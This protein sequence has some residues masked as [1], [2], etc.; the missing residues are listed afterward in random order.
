MSLGLYGGTFDPIHLGHLVLAESL[1]EICGIERIAFVPAA[2]PPHKRDRR[3]A[4]FEDRCQMVK[5]A[6]VQNPHFE[7]LELEATREGP[8]YTIDTV[9]E[10]RSQ[11]PNRIHLMMGADT[12]SELGSWHRI[13]EL[14]D[15]VQLAV[16]ARPGYDPR[17]ISALVD[18]LRPDQIDQVLAAC[19][20]TPWIDVASSKIRQRVATGQSIRYLV[21]KIFDF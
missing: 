18:N 10:L 4:S 12:V 11:E 15:Q 8:S 3:I 9:R 1:Q 7:M 6:I 19:H 20:E 5:L 14:L 13:D 2:R 16:A 17:E 21:P